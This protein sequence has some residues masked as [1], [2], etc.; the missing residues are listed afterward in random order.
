MNFVFIVIMKQKAFNLNNQ[1]SN[2]Q[3]TATCFFLADWISG[4]GTIVILVRT[5]QKSGRCKL[6]LLQTTDHS[7]AITMVLVEN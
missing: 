6:A 4:A 3:S 1:C 2:F 5:T 7:I